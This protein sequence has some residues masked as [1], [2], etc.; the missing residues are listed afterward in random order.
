M[1]DKIKAG[2]AALGV[3]LLVI[4]LMPRH[5]AKPKDEEPHQITITTAR[6]VKPP[7]RALPADVLKA[8]ALYSEATSAR[9]AATPV[10]ADKSQIHLK[11]RIKAT[12]SCRGGD[13]DAVAGDL[14]HSSR[15]RILITLEPL[16]RGR[17]LPSKLAQEVRE[18]D[19]FR[20]TGRVFSFDVDSGA[21]AVGLYLCKDDAGVGRCSTKRKEDIN[22]PLQFYATHQ[23]HPGYK[24][25]DRLYYFQPLFLDGGTVKTLESSDV[26]K[27]QLGALTAFIEHASKGAADSRKIA[28]SAAEVMNTIHSEPLVYQPGSAAPGSYGTLAIELPYRDPTCY[29]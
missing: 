9:L 22:K 10:A 20:N 26:R 13:L 21:R 7:S 15:R 29:R 12:K 16:P 17:T 28:D 1:D 27:D 19:L 14:R 24:A 18:E 25:P 3:T 8:R 6:P 4:I 11:F 2:L 5:E 23:D